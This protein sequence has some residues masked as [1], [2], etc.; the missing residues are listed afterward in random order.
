MEH[1]GC[2]VGGGRCLQ[3][4]ACY[5]LGVF[6]LRLGPWRLVLVDALRPVV[7][8]ERAI[9]EESVNRCGNKGISGL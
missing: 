4:M 8:P 9:W 3:C 1:K 6:F 5:V 7:C 2:G